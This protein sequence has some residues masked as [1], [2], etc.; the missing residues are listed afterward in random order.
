MNLPPDVI[1]KSQN[2]SDVSHEGLITDELMTCTVVVNHEENKLWISWYWNDTKLYNETKCLYHFDSQST[3]QHTQ[4]Y[5]Y[6]FLSQSGPMPQK[7]TWSSVT[8][9][10]PAWTPQ[11]PHSCPSVP[12]CRDLWLGTQTTSVSASLEHQ[13]AMSTCTHRGYR[14][15][16]T[17]TYWISKYMEIQL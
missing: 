15:T 13:A 14:G 6:W 1:G 17:W 11:S 7:S 9:P 10:T 3:Y 12:P 5:K 4:V 8:P 2:I 16:T